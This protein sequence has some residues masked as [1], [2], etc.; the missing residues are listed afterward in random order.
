MD[1][2]FHCHCQVLLLHTHHL[3]NAKV[4]STVVI[5]GRVRHTLLTAETDCAHLAFA[6]A[7]FELDAHAT[8]AVKL[9]DCALLL[10]QLWG[11]VKVDKF[12]PGPQ[13]GVGVA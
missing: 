4:G 2:L 11:G 12:D 8:V 13:L 7:M 5:T 10:V 3:C 6:M 9:A 1:T